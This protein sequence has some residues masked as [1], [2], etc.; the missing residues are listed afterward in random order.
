L[1]N[2]S[3]YKTDSSTIEP[4]APQPSKQQNTE[5]ERLVFDREEVIDLIDGDMELLIDMMESFIGDIGPTLEK[6]KDAIDSK[7]AK[8]LE[9]EAHR[10]KSVLGYFAA[11]RAREQAYVLEKDG[12]AADFENSEEDYL[13]LQLELTEL[14]KRLE[15]FM[16]ESSSTM[17]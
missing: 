6:I 15:A 4:R 3:H 7:D 13:L 10:L 17:S 12:A 9:H 1:K 2:I 5:N 11:T 8:A 16:A 14:Q